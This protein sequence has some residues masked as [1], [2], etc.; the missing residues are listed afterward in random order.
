MQRARNRTDL[1]LLRR[2]AGLGRRARA[3]GQAFRAVAFHRIGGHGHDPVPLDIAINW[4]CR[5]KIRYRDSSRRQAL[6]G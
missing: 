6:I 5:Y 1:K 3:G 2:L 4:A